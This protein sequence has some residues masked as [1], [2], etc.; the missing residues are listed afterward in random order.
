MKLDVLIIT[1]MQHTQR[2]LNFEPYNL[3]R[4]LNSSIASVRQD[5]LAF[6]AGGINQT[7]RTDPERPENDAGYSFGVR[8]TFAKCARAGRVMGA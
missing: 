6:F 2:T 7:H 3:N 8:Q 5:M 1:S 4:F